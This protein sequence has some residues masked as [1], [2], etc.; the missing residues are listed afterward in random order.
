MPQPHRK[1]V[2]HYHEPGDFHEFT[3]S[4]YRRL[5]LLTND[6]YRTWLARSIDEAAAQVQFELVA[7][8][9]MPEHVHLLVWP[10]RSDTTVD[11]ISWFLAAVKRPVSVKV[12]EH[13]Q[14]INGQLLDRL[15]IRTRPGT[16]AF[17][18]W[19]E[20]PGYDRNLKTENAVTASIE[21][22]HHNPVTR[23]LVKN[24][25]QW[26]WSSARW[27]LSDRSLVDPDLPTIHGPPAVLYH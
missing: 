2:K 19:Q 1:L 13:L 26:K 23:K 15:T 20:G 4:C 6:T 5:K 8:V 18:F 22:I 10:T 21:Y 14:S 9:F 16:T 17:R 24:I 25:A 7:F 3:F 11:D 12:K 27:Y